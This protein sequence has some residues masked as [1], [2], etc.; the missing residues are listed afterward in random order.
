MYLHIVPIN[1]ESCGYTA[2]Q[3]VIILSIKTKN[4]VVLKQY[5]QERGGGVVSPTLLKLTSP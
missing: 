5:M 4:V 3:N 2:R 1:L